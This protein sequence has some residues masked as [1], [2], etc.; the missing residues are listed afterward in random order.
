MIATWIFVIL[1]ILIGLGIIGWCIYYIIDSGDKLAPIIGI[2]ITFILCVA[3]IFGLLFWLYGT[4]SGERAQKSTKSNISGGIERV[5]TVYDINGKIIKTYDGKF[6]VDSSS[7]NKV[8]FDDENG[9]RHTIY[10]T[11]ATVTIDEKGE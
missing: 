1:T 7:P 9:K 5:I 6:D 8:M 11:T 4:E 3:I 2:V 10:F